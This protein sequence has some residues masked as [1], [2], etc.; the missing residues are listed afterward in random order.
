MNKNKGEGMKKEPGF[1][2][3]VY[4]RYPSVNHKSLCFPYY[5][6]EKLHYYYD[7][8]CRW[9]AGDDADPDFFPR[10]IVAIASNGT[11]LL[12]DGQQTC[13]D[14]FETTRDRYKN[15]LS[16]V[17]SLDVTRCEFRIKEDE[18]YKGSPHLQILVVTEEEMNEEIK[19]TNKWYEDFDR[20]NDPAYEYDPQQD[21]TEFAH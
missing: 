5:F 16:Q 1:G 21:D 15:K 12:S 11:W 2:D 9:Q 20:E 4:L 18:K 14:V 6:N 3:T 7:E 19:A 13:T 8:N 17:L 10:T